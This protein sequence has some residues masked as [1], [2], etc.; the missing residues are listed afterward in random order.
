M[1][2][3]KGGKIIVINS[4]INW[5]N[6]ISSIKQSNSFYDGI[7]IE[8]K[9]ENFGKILTK[10]KIT[11]DIFQIQNKKEDLNVYDL[12]DICSFSNGSFYMFKNFNLKIHQKNF[13]N[14]LIK[15]IQKQK[16]YEV[17]LQIY[18]PV[19]II[20]SNSLSKMPL[21]VNNDFLL[22]NIDYDQTFSFIFEYKSKKDSNG[23]ISGGALPNQ[24]IIFFQ[25]SIIY[26][27][28]EGLRLIRVFNLKIP[29]CNFDEEYF[30]NIDFEAYY[31]L[32]SKLLINLIYEK[33]NISNTLPAINQLYL[34]NSLNLI[35][36]KN[37]NE[38]LSQGLIYYLGIMKNKIFCIDPQRFKLNKDEI[39]FLYKLILKETVNEIMIILIPRIYDLNKIFD[40]NESFEN[41]SMNPL[42]LSMKSIQKDSIY[43]IDNGQFFDFHLT[44]GQNSKERIKLFF[45][46]NMTPE[47]VGTY[48]HN[49]IS[50]FEDNINKDN[51]EVESC[52]DAIGILRYK[53]CNLYQD[54]F[55][56]F[57]GTLSENILKS[58]LILDDFCPWFS[59]N[60][61][62][63]FK[64]LKF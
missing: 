54:V 16:A 25:F 63:W 58:C 2:Q 48:F 1:L 36:H 35:A 6:R 57:E 47:I 24:N 32:I 60:F 29:V 53:K 8:K 55:F 49:E 64:R 18:F 51:F 3:N 22:S 61:N 28:I 41:I 59:N 45:G 14:S 50:V 31:A 10:Y 17:L 56:S 4:T 20:I 37:Y 19:N 23:T 26:T 7:D 52:N 34:M 46:E 40:S 33:K 39:H 43:L 13:L 30:K 38:L 5:I 15:S 27:N 62:E 42:Q 21:Q 11:C 44:F 12:S 9:I